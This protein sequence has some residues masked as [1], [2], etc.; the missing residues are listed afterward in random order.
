[1][2]ITDWTEINSLM[3]ATFQNY[4]EIERVDSR[5]IQSQLL[6]ELLDQRMTLSPYLHN[7]VCSDPVFYDSLL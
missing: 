5:K 7:A 6:R 1:M 2:R 3:M 4:D